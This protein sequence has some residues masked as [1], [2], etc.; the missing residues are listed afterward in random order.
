LLGALLQQSM[1]P[2]KILVVDDGSTDE[3]VA[4]IEAYRRRCDRIRLIRHMTNHGA[5]AAVRTG[6]ASAGEELPLFAPADDF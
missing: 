3:S 6:I 2:Q 5:F 1:P 4:V